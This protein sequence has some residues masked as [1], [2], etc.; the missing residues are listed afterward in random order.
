M[1]EIREVQEND[2][3]DVSNFLHRSMNLNWSAKTWKSLFSYRWDCHR[4]HS[5]YILLDSDQIVGSIGGIFSRRLIK[6]K[7]EN[8]VCATSWSVL[9]KYRNHSIKLLMSLM[10]TKDVHF[11]TCG[12]LPELQPLLK[13]VFKNDLEAQKTY[14]FSYLPSFQ[15]D[16]VKIFSKM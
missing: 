12:S 13:I 6:G 2:F 11:R 9:P 1:V 3:E 14:F 5:G 7:W 10:R 16:K 8:F 4:Q 15:R